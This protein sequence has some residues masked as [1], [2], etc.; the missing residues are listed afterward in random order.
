MNI[1][2]KSYGSVKSFTTEIRDDAKSWNPHKRCRALRFTVQGDKA[3]PPAFPSGAAVKIKTGGSEE[4]LYVGQS[5]TYGGYSD[6]KRI[7]EFDFEFF[8][9]GAK[10]LLISQDVQ[11]VPPIYIIDGVEKEIEF[12]N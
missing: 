2:L 1:L 5:L 10:N 7:E 11:I 3:A 4:I 9:V 8:G 12:C 6:S